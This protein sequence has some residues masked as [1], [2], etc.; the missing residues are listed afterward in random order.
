MTPYFWPGHMGVPSRMGMPQRLSAFDTRDNGITAARLGLAIVVVASHSVS[1]GGYGP[2]PLVEL[3]TGTS[4]GFVAVIAF[5]ALSGFLLAG[6]RER[7]TVL[8]FLRNRALRILPGYWLALGFSILVAVPIAAAI[9]GVALDAGAAA[10]WVG[11]RLLFIYAPEDEVL[12]AAF[13][14]GKING[15][16]WT[17]GIELLCY[18]AL[19]VTP[20]RWLRPMVLGHLGLLC[21]LSLLAPELMGPGIT[22]VLAFVCGAA[23][24]LWRGW[25]PM[26]GW[27]AALGA[28][29]S[30]IALLLGALPL[31]TLLISYTALGLAWLPIRTDRDLSYGVY[32]LAYPIQKVL[33][34]AGVA[35]LGLPVMIAA[36]IVLVLPLAWASWHFI[37]QPALSIRTRRIDKP[38]V[39][40]AAPGQPTVEPLGLGI[41][42]AIQR[43]ALAEASA[44]A[45]PT[46]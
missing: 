2:E 34:T 4:I 6:S 26:S 32:V 23:A 41:D 30:A 11:P 18:A 27:T 10:G 36:S 15:S 21:G 25:I 12:T 20:R 28:G 22:L 37:E 5:F 24:W 40:R 33:V 39:S 35:S 14:G 17:L 29:G 16:L 19:A 9:S 45:S 7:T 43:L 31:A 38:V 44:T 13:H 1:L 8:A 42:P 46:I 3:S